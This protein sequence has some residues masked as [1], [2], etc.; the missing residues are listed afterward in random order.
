MLPLTIVLSIQPQ[1]TRGIS[2]NEATNPPMNKEV[3]NTLLHRKRKERKER[4][5][6]KKMQDRKEKK[7]LKDQMQC[8]KLQELTHLQQGGI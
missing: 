1:S 4:K 5:K 3:S 2:L 8:V 7:T 6:E